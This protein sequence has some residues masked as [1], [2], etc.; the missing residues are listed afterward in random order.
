MIQV[1]SVGT[2]NHGVQVSGK[3]EWLGCFVNIFWRFANSLLNIT[4]S[5]Y[6]NTSDL[7]ICAL[8]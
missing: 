2:K 7:D 6:F 8:P 3:R 4:F 1:C 5:K